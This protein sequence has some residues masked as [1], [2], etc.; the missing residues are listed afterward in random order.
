MS[1]ASHL[2]LIGLP[3]A[4]KST[5]GTALADRLGWPFVDLDKEIG[6]HAG[7]SIRE[8]FE[9]LGEARFRAFEREAT[10]RVAQSTVPMVIAPGGGW[11]TVPGLVERV[12]PPSQLVYLELSPACALERLGGA[13]EA[14]PL[15][16][17]PDPLEALTK[18]LATRRKL[19]VQADHTL[20]VEMMTRDE[21][22]KAIV[23]LACP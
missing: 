12:R 17:G 10:E 23:A 1:G 14:R 7:M 21:V 2:I 8:I 18:I 9:R 16:A 11:I 22:V 20:S 3:G 19:Y 4:G 13:V 5:I 6:E 15:L